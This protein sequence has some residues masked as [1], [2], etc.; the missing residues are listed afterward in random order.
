MGKGLSLPEQP[1]WLI[2][3]SV[4]VRAIASLFNAKKCLYDNTTMP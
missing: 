3:L 4:P 1:L 2:L